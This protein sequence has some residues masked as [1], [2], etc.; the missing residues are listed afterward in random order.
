MGGH[1]YADTVGPGTGAEN[2]SVLKTEEN[3]SDV[4]LATRLVQDDPL[5]RFDLAV[6]ISNDSDL[7]EEVKILNSLG[8]CL[9]VLNPHPKIESRGGKVK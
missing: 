2:V 7:S 6:I 3:G 9:G 5:D 1:R 8:E 4:K